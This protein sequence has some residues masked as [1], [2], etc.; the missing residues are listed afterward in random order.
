MAGE[1]ASACPALCV[2][3]LTA[4]GER[5][6]QAEVGAVLH[7][8]GARRAVLAGMLLALTWPEP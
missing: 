5:A 3:H 4:E 6:R 7:A 2:T 8:W 1:A